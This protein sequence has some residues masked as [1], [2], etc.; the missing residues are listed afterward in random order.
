MIYTGF[1]SVWL[2]TAVASGQLDFYDT[3]VDQE[4]D[5]AFLYCS[6]ASE[7]AWVPANSTPRAWMLPNRSVLDIGNIQDFL[8]YDIQDDNWTLVVKNV[9]Q[10]D[11]GLYHCLLQ[12]PEDDQWFVVRLGLNAAGPYF[13]AL[14]VEYKTNTVIGVSTA[15][16]F[17]VLCVGIYLL[18]RFKY[19]EPEVGDSS[20]SNGTKSLFAATATA[21][22]DPNFPGYVPHQGSFELPEK[23]KD[24][25]PGSGTDQVVQMHT[26]P[27][28][29]G[30]NGGFIQNETPL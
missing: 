7:M 15:A 9:S 20:K 5:T 26:E 27:G 28:D 13:Q 30:V 1:L 23:G 22:V 3:R 4:W 29:S 16:C 10:S 12:G 14:W 6:N 24:G 18:D 21:K 19:V 11:V 17:V 25:L 8:R 2:L